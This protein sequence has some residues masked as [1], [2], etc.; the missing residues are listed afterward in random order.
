MR[1]NEERLYTTL[2]AKLYC[3][4]KLCSNVD[5]NGKKTIPLTSYTKTNTHTD[6]HIPSIHQALWFY[7]YISH[8]GIHSVFLQP[9]GLCHALAT[10]NHVDDKL[11]VEMC[12]QHLSLMQGWDCRVYNHVICWKSPPPPLPPRR[13]APEWPLLGYVS[14]KGAYW[15]GCEAQAGRHWL[16]EKNKNREGRW[17]DSPLLHNSPS[18]TGGKKSSPPQCKEKPVHP[19]LIA[20]QTLKHFRAGIR[21]TLKPAVLACSYTIVAALQTSHHHRL[22]KHQ[23]H[24]NVHTEILQSNPVAA[25]QFIRFVSY[26]YSVP[27][28]P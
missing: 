3:I 4:E 20:L 12:L 21:A 23:P 24:L 19:P 13:P 27:V 2:F 18:M 1:P 7:F 8:L 16:I 15:T 14:R 5:I 11:V 22:V 28:Q 17:E 6:T 26:N 25:S 10:S 9:H